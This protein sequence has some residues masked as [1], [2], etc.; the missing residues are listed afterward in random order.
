MLKQK[1]Q[2]QLDALREALR[3][4]KAKV[5]AGGILDKLQEVEKKS[6]ALAAPAG[7]FALKY[8]QF[9]KQVASVYRSV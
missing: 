5:E 6:A 9:R 7:A 2:K 1:F 8:G 4:I 3:D